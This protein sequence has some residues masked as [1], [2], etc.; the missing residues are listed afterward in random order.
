MSGISAL[1]GL[2]AAPSLDVGVV[3]ESYPCGSFIAPEPTESPELSR[4]L[5][6]MSGLGVTEPPALR[7]PA[8]DFGR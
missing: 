6:M 1:F 7:P 4:P 2:E 5:M 8:E 3:D